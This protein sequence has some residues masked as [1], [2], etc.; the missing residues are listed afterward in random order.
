MRLWLSWV[1]LVNTTVGPATPANVGYTRAKLECRAN[2]GRTGPIPSTLRDAGLDVQ[3][4]STVI[5]VAEASGG[6]ARVWGRVGPARR[7]RAAG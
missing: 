4:D 2:T 5:G 7:L 3:K 1:Y 6:E